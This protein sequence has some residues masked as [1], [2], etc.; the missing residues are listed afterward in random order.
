MNATLIERD[1]STQPQQKDYVF[2]KTSSG[3]LVPD[4]VQGM[5][6]VLYVRLTRPTTVTV[7]QNAFENP[8]YLWVA[9]PF[10][11]DDTTSDADT[12]GLTAEVDSITPFDMG[13]VRKRVS[14]ESSVAVLIPY[15]AEGQTLTLAGGVSASE[16]CLF[17][18]TGVEKAERRIRKDPYQVAV[19]YKDGS[20]RQ[21]NAPDVQ[22]A[23]K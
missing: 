1:Q 22:I 8:H 23:F 10:N 2:T 11:V 13:R 21:L 16:E 3:F 7:G 14:N 18:V 12:T 20:V 6:T 19:G 5:G 9:H 4:E 17:E 15:G